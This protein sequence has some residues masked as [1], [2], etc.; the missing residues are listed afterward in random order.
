MEV[1]TPRLRPEVTLRSKG[2]GGQQV[3]IAP[4]CSDW[5]PTSSWSKQDKARGTDRDFEPDMS[6]FWPV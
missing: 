4:D 1:L 6:H 5:L 2:P 3:D